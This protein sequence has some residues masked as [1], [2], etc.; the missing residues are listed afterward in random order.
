MTKVTLYWIGL[1]IAAVVMGFVWGADW[2]S[3]VYDI[4]DIV[5]IPYRYGMKALDGVFCYFP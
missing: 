4:T 3:P 1:V 2:A 5:W